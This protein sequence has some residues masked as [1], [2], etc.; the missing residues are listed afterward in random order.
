MFLYLTISMYRHNV[1]SRRY[2]YLPY[3]PGQEIDPREISINC[4]TANSLGGLL[5]SLTIQNNSILNDS[6]N[7][8][9]VI[10]Q[11]SQCLW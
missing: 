8:A 6:V 1:Y 3:L 9:I 10:N 11:V 5:I 2:P 4:K 7:A